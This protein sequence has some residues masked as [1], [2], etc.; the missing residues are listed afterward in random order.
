MTDFN[1]S[2]SGVK[3]QELLD[4]VNAG[5]KV[6]SGTIGLPTFLDNG[7]GS[8]TIG[9]A[10][11]WI[12]PENEYYGKL[13]KV[14][15][16][17]N[18]FL[19]TDLVDNFIIINWNAGSPVMEVSLDYEA[20]DE[21]DYIPLFTIF[22]EGD[23][24]CRLEWSDYAVGQTEKS[25]WKDLR[26]SRFQH[27]N[28][29]AISEF[30]TRNIALTAGHA[31]IT[32]LRQ[33]LLAFDSTVD[34]L[35]FYYHVG[36]VWTKDGTV[37]QYNN[38]QY[39]DGTDLQTLA[40]NDFTVNW[41]YRGI[42]SEKALG[43]ILGTESYNTL[44]EALESQ[45][46]SGLPD[47]LN[48]H[49]LLVGRIIVKKDDA[50]AS[51]IGS[52]FTQTF[53]AGG[54]SEHNDLSGLQ[55]GLANEYYHLTQSQLELVDEF[56]EN[57][58]TSLDNEGQVISLPASAIEG[59][60]DL[61]LKGKTY[62]NLVTNPYFE[63]GDDSWI[64]ATETHLI[65]NNILELT[66]TA[67]YGYVSQFVSTQKDGDKIFYG[68]LVK[69]TSSSV[70]LQGYDG[71][72]TTKDYHSGSNQFELL[73]TTQIQGIDSSATRIYV[74]DGRGTGWDT[75]YIKAFYIINM[76]ALGIEDKTAEEMKAYVGECIDG[77]QSVTPQK[78][79]S[80]GKNL[81]DGTYK[82][83][84][85]ISSS[86]GEFLTGTDAR[87]SNK[88]LVEEDT[89]YTLNGDDRNGVRFDD[90]NGNLLSFIASDTDIGLRTFTTPSNCK[91][92]Y[93]FYSRYGTDI[94][95][96]MLNIGSTP[97]SCEPYTETTAYI[98]EEL[99]RVPNGTQD[100]INPLTGKK[101]QGINEYVLQ[102]SDVIDMTN[103]TYSQ[104]ISI[105]KTTFT[106]SSLWTTSIDGKVFINGKTEVATSHPD[107]ID[108][109]GKFATS[110]T[111]LRIFV[112]SATYP[113][114][115]AAQADL[116][117]TIIY[118]QLETP[119]TTQLPPQ[120]LKS[121]V[122]GSINIEQIIE[123]YNFY[124]SGFTIVNSSYPIDELKEVVKF[125]MA[126]GEEM[127]ISIGSCTIAGDGLSFTSTEL[128]DDDFVWCDFEYT[129]TGTYP[130]IDYTVPT[131]LK[132]QVNDNSDGVKLVDKKVNNL[133]TRVQGIN[134]EYSNLANV[135]TS[136]FVV[137]TST[138]GWT[139]DDC[140][141][142]CDGTDDQTEINNAITVLPSA[143]GE[144]VILDGT[145]NITA[146]ININKNNVSI[147]GNG[148]ATILKRMWNS[149]TS[150]GVATLTS[151]INCKVKDL[152]VDGN[153]V[154]YTSNNNFGILLS[155]SSNN[156]IT[157]N[158]C[159]NS[160]GIFISAS[161]NNTVTGNTCNNNNNY[162][163]Y[164]DFTSNE[165]TITDNVCNNNTNYGIFISASSN[166]TVIGNTCNNN[167]TYGIRLDGG[168]N[169]STVTGNT[170]NNNT[171][172]GILLSSSSNNTIT[173]NTCN[174]N[175]NFGI[176]LNFSSNNTVTGNTCI[177]GTG[178]P[179][180][181][182][183]SQYTIKLNGTGNNYNLISS[184]QCMGKA[185]VIEGGT[186]NTSVNNKFE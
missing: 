110:A 14:T 174:N 37:T 105:N 178:L 48:L 117:G 132:D 24:L 182:T 87:T 104:L 113:D 160:N 33:T 16:A 138:A 172:Y 108:L 5:H 21:S 99:H 127:N 154:A 44:A 71:A 68:A 80:V 161:S 67:T 53:T 79:I 107:T 93:I 171:N 162:G 10:V 84:T 133:E 177:R 83:N 167:T 116:A 56:V 70:Y 98:N 106:G 31:W 47:V 95:E 155:S 2:Y 185:V 128:A 169:E 51:N 136:R 9:E 81:F 76:T 4:E 120:L 78:I 15:V 22:R 121:E 66:A 180:D 17:G 58:Y 97:L 27:E 165:N 62:T 176:L 152:Q 35:C 75:I 63:D 90:A 65:V 6:A 153:K 82:E 45:P 61:I 130:T 29:L 150:E 73:N 144:I 30:G 3:V 124:S 115:A 112:A 91:Y 12:Y 181:Y 57:K 96:V 158:T 55:G 43:I 74:R 49:A 183:A 143:G 139:S 114:L 151:V 184:N 28:G 50:T 126:T 11:V 8:V 46:I 101:V 41:L 137:G 19:L 134:E 100:T 129:P 103:L 69:S 26:L 109:V 59:T 13:Q 146:K 32:T 86:T 39:D 1:L 77:T 54:V 179:S 157:G 175:T 164:L 18:T 85:F 20:I 145:Y 38:D 23:Y 40:V 131:T 168:S 42:G 166:N 149:S 88:I 25:R 148:N 119:I 142:L 102:A 186:S 159:N 34:D 163:I 135:R 122:G 147:R 7:G 170:C 125:N 123:D 94:D 60:L 173:G 140:D 118:Y 141:Y 92:V 52:A 156:T 89:V 111:S 72:I 36:G 64:F